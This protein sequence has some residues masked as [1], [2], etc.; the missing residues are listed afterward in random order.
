MEEKTDELALHL[1]VLKQAFGTLEEALREP[2]SILVR[3]ATIQRFEYTFELTWKLFRRVAKVEGIETASPRQ[4]IR[5]AYDVGLL[6]DVDAWFEL[7]EDRSR[8]SHTY[9]AATAQ[10]V[11]ESATRLPGLLRPVAE[12]VRSR[13]LKS[14]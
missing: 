6:E 2:Y 13:Y 4:A 8:T 9:S 3:D 10:E 7:L 1:A 5:A 12:E 14:P 11:Y